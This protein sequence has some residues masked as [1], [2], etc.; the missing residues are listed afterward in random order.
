MRDLFELTKQATDLR[1][2]EH[3]AADMPR[4]ARRL[5]TEEL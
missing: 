3:H 4:P 2:L 5:A 1:F